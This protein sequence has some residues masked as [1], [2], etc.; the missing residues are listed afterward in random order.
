MYPSCH[1]DGD[2]RI[3]STS[4]AAVSE[5]IIESVP[6]PDQDAPLQDFTRQRLAPLVLVCDFLLE[7]EREVWLVPSG[8]ST[9]V[10][11]PFS[12]S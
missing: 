1:S 5:D 11:G 8:G 10:V 2:R 9:N 12:G 6:G 3:A 4:R 7:R